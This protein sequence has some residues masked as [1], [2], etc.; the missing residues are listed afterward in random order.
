[1]TSLR[2]RLFAGVT[3]FV[4]LAALI[5]SVVT[6]RWA[7]REAIEIQDAVLLQVGG[8]AFS[9]RVS[10]ETQ[11]EQSVDDEARIRIDEFDAAHPS[12]L[13][14]ATRNLPDGLQTINPGDQSWRV[15][16]RTRADRSRFLVAQTT[17]YRDEVANDSA[18]R[19]V[20]PLA[21]LVPCLLALIGFVIHVSFKP[22]AGTAKALD[23]EKGAGFERI[24]RR[25]M[26]AELLPFIDSINRLLDRQAANVEQQK[27]FIA[28][29]AH[30]MRSPITALGLQVENLS[31]TEM[32]DEAKRRV[33]TL[34]EG[35]RRTGHLIEQLL[36]LARSENRNGDGTTVKLDAV[37]KNVVA[38]FLPM[39]ASQRVDLGFALIQPV[40]VFGDEALL[41]AMVRNVIDNAVKY[42]PPNG[43]IDISLY[44]NDGKARLHIT[45]SGPGMK[46]NEI[47][48]ACEPFYR[49]SR[50][51]GEGTG[52][53]L[54]IVQ[55]V[56][57]SLGGN[58]S[59]V[60]L[61]E[62]DQAGLR[63]EISIPSSATAVTHE[64]GA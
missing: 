18:L 16:L 20:W 63:V 4:I 60:S 8:I 29:A 52:L 46:A 61:G 10:T 40:S 3:G 39:T 15:N 14:L 30:E 51:R 48:R 5:A 38:D 41:T 28:D 59:L 32:S 26:P 1:M 23:A 19:T 33:E 6:F 13:V 44:S 58:V 64:P 57:T 27:R 36:T 22:V 42:T 54:S 24:S 49:G 34:R 55:Q 62:K 47:V 25:Q 53:G 2:G 11:A 31:N 45:D 17:A 43:Q 9:N 50:P 7:Y 56:A 21:A 37:V 35:I 12:T